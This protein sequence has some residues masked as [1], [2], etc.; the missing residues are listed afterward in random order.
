MRFAANSMPV[1]AAV[2]G[3]LLGRLIEV[4]FQIDKVDWIVSPTTIGIGIGIFV[5]L[6]LRDHML[7]RYNN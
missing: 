1:I 7:R 5:G 4:Q 3:S 6:K 2:L